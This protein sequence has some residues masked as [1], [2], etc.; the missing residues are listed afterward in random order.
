MD[1]VLVV[2]QP[3]VKAGQQ[4][5]VGGSS[6]GSVSRPDWV[7]RCQEASSWLEASR[8]RFLCGSVML[9]L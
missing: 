2:L 3:L 6:S 4:V 9:A 1:L 7:E 8:H 5:S